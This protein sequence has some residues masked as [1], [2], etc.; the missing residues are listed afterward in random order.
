MIELEG[1]FMKR[2]NSKLLV[3]VLLMTVGFVP[4]ANGEEFPTLKSMDK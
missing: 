2:V 3:V 1:M 4:A